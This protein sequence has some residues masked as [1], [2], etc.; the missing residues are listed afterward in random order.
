MRLNWRALSRPIARVI[1][2][3]LRGQVEAMKTLATELMQVLATHK[4]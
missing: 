4:P 3:N 1:S 2:R